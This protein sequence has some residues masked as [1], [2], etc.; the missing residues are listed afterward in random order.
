MEYRGVYSNMFVGSLFMSVIFIFTYCT[1]NKGLL[2]INSTHVQLSKN[3]NY[4]FSI[5]FE[6]RVPC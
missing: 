1:W 5:S 6:N 3:I 4:C 2:K